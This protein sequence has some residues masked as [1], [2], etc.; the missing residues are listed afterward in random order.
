MDAEHGC[1]IEMCEEPPDVEEMLN[2]TAETEGATE[3]SLHALSGS[4]NPRSLR[5]WGSVKGKELTILVDSG[6]TVTVD[7]NL[8]TGVSKL[9]E[10]LNL[11]EEISGDPAAADADTGDQAYRRPTRSRREAKDPN[12]IYY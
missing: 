12:Y 7:L 4:F 2:L 10:D 6:S 8:D 1:L 9:K 5:L 11:R 3:I